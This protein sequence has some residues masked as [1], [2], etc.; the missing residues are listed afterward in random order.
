MMH[1]KQFLFALFFFTISIVFSQEQ[2]RKCWIYFRDKDETVLR[3][4]A[5]NGTAHEIS[6]A[7][8]ITERA[9]KRRERW[10]LPHNL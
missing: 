9:L 1:N 6:Q 3:T 2:P 10:F 8:G 7:I 4:L 5:A